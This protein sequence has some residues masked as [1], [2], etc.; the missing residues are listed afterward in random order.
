MPSHSSDGICVQAVP[1]A[2][3]PAAGLVAGRTT[4]RRFTNV[5]KNE[6][7]TWGCLRNTVPFNAPAV[8]ALTLSG[9]EQVVRRHS[10]DPGKGHER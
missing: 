1:V 4:K 9:L 3:A 6:G 10:T 2:D 5:W 8:T 7:G